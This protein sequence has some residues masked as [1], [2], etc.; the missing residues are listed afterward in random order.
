MKSE[1]YLKLLAFREALFNIPSNEYKF[2]PFSSFPKGCCEFTSYLLAKYLSEE[3]KINDVMLVHGENRYKL[4]LRHVWLIIDGYNIDLTADQFS[5]T[6]QTVFCER[7]SIW[8][9]RF[10]IYDSY[11]P[12]I[13]FNHFH[14][15]Y[16]EQLLSDYRRV[17][18][19]L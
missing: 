3:L 11:Q 12:N 4:S 10:R 6:K 9:K 5:S 19:S 17:V 16:S 8:H 14:E 1:V 15:E 2:T 7:N 18:S 13:K